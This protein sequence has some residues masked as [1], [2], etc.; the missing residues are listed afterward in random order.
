MIHKGG[1]VSVEIYE[2]AKIFKLW[3]NGNEINFS[4]E[5][6]NIFATEFKNFFFYLD[7]E[8]KK[9]YHFYASVSNVEKL[10]ELWDDFFSVSKFEDYWEIDIDNDL[11]IGVKY[12][13]HNCM[14][15]SE[16]LFLSIWR[17]Q[18]Y[19]AIK[20]KEFLVCS[21]SNLD[22]FSKLYKGFRD[23]EFYY[24]YQRAEKNGNAVAIPK[25]LIN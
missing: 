4:S 8:I 14:S 25:Q 12:P 9:T 17:H 2:K 20:T 6:I 21:I 18:Y 11:L 1:K 3:S 10:R 13:E 24:M 23:T 15:S 16:E 7:D 5:T 19:D 22:K